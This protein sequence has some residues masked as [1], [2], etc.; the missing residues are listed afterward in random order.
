[1]VHHHTHIAGS[2]IEADSTQL[3][4]ALGDVAC[5]LRDHEPTYLRIGSS[6]AVNAENG[7]PWTSS[8]LCQKP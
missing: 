4:G 3:Q 5:V 2:R 8:G 6:P 1:M 7:H